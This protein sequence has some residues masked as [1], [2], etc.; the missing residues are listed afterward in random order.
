[1]HKSY[2]VAIIDHHISRAD[3]AARVGFLRR[4]VKL[5][6]IFIDGSA[7]TTGLRIYER[8]GGR[9][10]IELIRLPEE[11]RKDPAYRRAA[12][13]TADIAFLC[14]PDEA[15]IEA[16][17]MIEDPDTV[18]IDTSTAHRTA[19]GWVYGFPE[20][21]PQQRAAIAEAKRVANPGCHASGFVALV[22]PLVQQGILEPG[23]LLSCFSLTGY[24]GG[25]KKMIA[26]YEDSARS[27]LLDAP[28]QYGLTQQHKHLKEMKALCALENEPVFCPIVGDF[29]SGMEVTVPL[30]ARQVNGTADDI[31]DIYRT[32]YTD[33]LV[34]FTEAPDSDGLLSAAALAGRDDM[35][36]SVFGNDTRILL[37][38]RFDNLGKGASG[39]AIQN[40][41]IL[42]GIDQAMGLNV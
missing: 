41:N 12:L 29:Y 5:K 16:V 22:A 7:G 2:M 35:E 1:M 38:A 32:Y 33:G 23:A 30:F 27:A 39:A 25:G 31:R 18:V 20:L 24:S 26:A 34:R 36:I 6:K 14:L 10:D 17:G 15:A 11:E 9:T 13:N 3:R 37:T 42:L 4:L 21:N 19:P 28:R 40:L 8:I